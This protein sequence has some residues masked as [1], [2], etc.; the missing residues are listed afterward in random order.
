ML[1]I[2]MHQRYATFLFDTLH[3]S[4]LCNTEALKRRKDRKPLITS[5]QNILPVSFK[6]RSVLMELNRASCNPERFVDKEAFNDVLDT[7]GFN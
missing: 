7:K 5:Y 4:S 6:S 1:E 3:G 2:V